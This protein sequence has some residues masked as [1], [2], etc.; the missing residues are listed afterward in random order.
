[1]RNDIN[2]LIAFCFLALIANPVNATTIDFESV[3]SGTQLTNE[4]ESLGVL[5]S[6]TDSYAGLVITEGQYG[7][8][9]FGNSPNHL[10][11]GGYYGGTTT[12]QFVD[13]SDPATPRGVSTFSILLGDGSPDTETFS[14]TFRDM[15]G[16][17]LAGPVG[18]TTTS[19][20][21]L[22]Q[23]TS[24]SLGDLIGFVDI[25][26]DIN[27]PSGVAFDDLSFSTVPVPGAAWFFGS[28]LLGLIGLSRRDKAA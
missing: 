23:E 4:F 17:I 19:N 20:G 15:A 11:H 18:Y 16:T 28:G 21:L 5:F 8:S 22:I 24:S 14:I 26:L 25:S 13:P 1:M 6:G 2:K 7:T 10:V 3:A 12:L 9:N 27:S